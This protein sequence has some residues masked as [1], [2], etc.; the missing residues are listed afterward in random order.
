MD[1]FRIISK[2]LRYLERAMDYDEPD[3]DMISPGSLKIT[4]NRW[5]A[6]MDQ[7]SKEE[8]NAYLKTRI[9]KNVAIK[10]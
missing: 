5:M 9:H 7:L 6:I 2:I 4:D 8:F 3:M 1:N 10:W